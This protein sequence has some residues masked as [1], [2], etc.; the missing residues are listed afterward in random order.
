MMHGTEK[1]VIGEASYLIASG[2]SIF[3][4]SLTKLIRAIVETQANQF[5]ALSYY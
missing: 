4:Q 3:K 5:E 1:L 2:R